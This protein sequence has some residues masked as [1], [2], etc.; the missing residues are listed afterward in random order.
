M[1]N[2]LKELKNY[3]IDL[4]LIGLAGYFARSL[5]KAKKFQ[6]SCDINLNAFDTASIFNIKKIAFKEQDMRN[7]KLGAFFGVL[8]CDIS[9]LEFTDR[10]YDLSIDISQGIIELTVP[11]NIY[12]IITTNSPFKI[13]DNRTSSNL[14]DNILV[15]NANIDF[16]ILK[17]KD[18]Q[19]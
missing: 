6:V 13:I 1:K 8:E 15:I 4:G 16:G 11:K 7:F 2:K 14:R 12:V 17:I 3:L 9:E 5:Y 19:E 10:E 18:R